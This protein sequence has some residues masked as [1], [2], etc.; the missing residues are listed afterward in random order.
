MSSRSLSSPSPQPARQIG[1]AAPAGAAATAPAGARSCTIVVEIPVLFPTGMPYTTIRR[2]VRLNFDAPPRQ[3]DER[4]FSFEEEITVRGDQTVPVKFDIPISSFSTLLEDEKLNGIVVVISWGPPVILEAP[5]AQPTIV[6]VE[7]IIET[8]ERK[9]SI[10]RD[11]QGQIK[12][13]T[14]KDA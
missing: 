11:G 7:N 1:S 5:P 4:V 13:A 12:G 3:D 6:H 14:V 2:S 9:V 10:E 8:P